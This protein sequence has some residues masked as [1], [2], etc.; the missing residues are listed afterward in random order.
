MEYT[1][2]LEKQILGRLRVDN[3]WW[4]ENQIESD[5]K[6]IGKSVRYLFRKSGV[7]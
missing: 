2:I 6:E 1:E 3:P 7:L 5:Y 4:T